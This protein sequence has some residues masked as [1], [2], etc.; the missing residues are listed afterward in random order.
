M[1]G[2]GGQGAQ[3]REVERVKP[4]VVPVPRHLEVPG[5][6]A[7]EGTGARGKGLL[8]RAVHPGLGGDW[9]LHVKNHLLEAVLGTGACRSAQEPRLV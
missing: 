4:G 6:Y 9:S 3:L 1:S 2:L 7:P 8:G 5:V